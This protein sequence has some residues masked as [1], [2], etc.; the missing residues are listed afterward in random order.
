V[1]PQIEPGQSELKVQKA[2][3]RGPALQNFPQ[4]SLKAQEV[5]ASGPSRQYFPQV[6]LKVQEALAFGP[7][8]QYFPQV[9]SRL[10]VAPL[11]GPPWHTPAKRSRSSELW[12][13]S[14]S[15]C[16]G[17]TD[18]LPSTL[19]TPQADPENANRQTTHNDIIRI[20]CIDWNSFW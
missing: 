20:F 10:Q 12:S 1:D 17:S 2:L 4:D 18:E 9:T 14:C 5:L 8:W 11:L 15:S 3:A 7:A 16:E 19:D 13:G 6:S